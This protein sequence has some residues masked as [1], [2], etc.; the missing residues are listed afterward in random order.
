M[1]APHPNQRLTCPTCSRRFY[2]DE[3]EAPPFCSERCKLVD[4]GRWLNEEYGLPHEGDPGDAPVEY[5]GEE[6]DDDHNRTG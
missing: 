3:T 5:R 1:S 6:D 4:L 2:L